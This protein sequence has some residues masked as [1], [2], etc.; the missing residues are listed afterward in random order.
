MSSTTLVIIAAVV[1]SIALMVF[2]L[3][4]GSAAAWGD[5]H[6]P[7]AIPWERN[8]PYDWSEDPDYNQETG[9]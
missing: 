2:A 1:G 8:H 9:T 5:K 3:C 7:P 4:L 6:T